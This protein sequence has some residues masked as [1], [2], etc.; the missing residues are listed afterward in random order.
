MSGTVRIR[1]AKL[2]KVRF[3]SH[4]DAARIWERALRRAS[5]PVA[6]SQG[7]SPRPKLS[8]GLALSTGHESLGEYLDVDLAPAGAPEI[9]DVEELPA[10]LEPCL[11]V[12]F[13]VQAA[14]AIPP[15]TPSLQQAVV[16][17]T[18]RIEVVGTTGDDLGERV[19]RVL[20]APELV[21]TRERKGQAV[22]DDVRPAVL[23]LTRTED[24]HFDGRGPEVVADLATQPRGL[25]PSELVGLLGPGVAEGR[26]CRMHQWMSAD[27]ALREPVTLP[28]PATS[29]PHA[30][31]RAS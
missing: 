23:S 11:P 4:R 6:Y 15:G 2:G 25:R 27:G 12:G 1:F 21:I 13:H 9:V 17:C 7:F 5:L 22:V 19:A 31:L 30:E 10:R 29:A 18:W 3:T 20:S 26:V 28:Q 24:P 14:V 16:R 8:F